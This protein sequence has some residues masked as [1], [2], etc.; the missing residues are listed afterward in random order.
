MT[1]EM[2]DPTKPEIEMFDS[3]LAIESPSFRV[4]EDCA[5]SEVTRA[6]LMKR[7]I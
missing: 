6:L 3:E 1:S 4:C 5:K 2:E 7:Q